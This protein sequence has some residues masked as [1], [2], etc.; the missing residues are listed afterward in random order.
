MTS[1]PGRS[2]GEV[3]P[4]RGAADHAQRGSVGAIS[5]GFTLVEVLVAL[6]ITA[7]ALLAGVQATSALTRNAERQGQLLLAQICAENELIRTKLA[8]ELPGAGSSSASCSQGGV[9]L[10]VQRNV[11]PTPNPNFRRVDAIVQQDG[12]PVLQ[13]STVVGRW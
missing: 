8:G 13:L 6:A 7:I 11:Q 9:T 12:V 3:R 1:P 4:P 2:Q 5:R 10:Q